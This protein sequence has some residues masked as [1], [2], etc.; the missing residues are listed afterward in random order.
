MNISGI[1]PSASFYSYNSIKINELRNQQISAAME[2]RQASAEKSP[3]TEKDIM[4]EQSFSS[5]DFAQNYQPDASYELKGIDSDIDKLD[6]EKAVSDLEK[7]KILEQYQY[8][9]GDTPAVTVKPVETR[10]NSLRTGENF[11]L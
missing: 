5:Y 7:D 2:A 8:F 4:P 11:V 3:D 6:V 9:V 1:R 10:D